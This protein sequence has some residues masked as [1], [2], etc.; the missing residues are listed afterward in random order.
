[1]LLG[2]ALTQYKIAFGEKQNIAI[3]GPANVGKSTLYNQLI[4]SKDDRAEVSPIP[5]TTRVNQEA[6]AGLFVM[7]DTP[8]ADA[9]GEVGE[10]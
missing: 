8:G 1:M 10:A 4:R 6:D 5:G 2:L 3:V 9:V 7:V